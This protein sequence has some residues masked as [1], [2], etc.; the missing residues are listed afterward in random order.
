MPLANIIWIVR[1]EST[2]KKLISF[3]QTKNLRLD[4]IVQLES[5]KRESL[6]ISFQALE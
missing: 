2:S 3:A 1:N 4:G 5:S 6:T